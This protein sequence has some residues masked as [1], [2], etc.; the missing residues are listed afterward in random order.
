MKHYT[1]KYYK[2]KNT[3][4]SKDNIWMTKILL[5][6]ILLLSCLIYVNYSSENKERFKKEVLEKNINFS[7]I[8]NLYEKYFGTIQV[9]D[10]KEELVFNEQFSYQDIKQVDNYYEVTVLKEY[11]M[12]FLSSGIIVY[13]GKKENFGDCVIVQGNDG[14]DIWYG[15]VEVIEHSL[16]DYVTSATILGVAKTEKIKLAFIKDGIH[17]SYDEY[18][19]KT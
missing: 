12:P 11:M 13:M 3:N 8:N 15:N 6:I 5:S 14:V 17:I 19:T 4:E 1:S 2:R 18:I 9:S 7:K 10:T 16:Y